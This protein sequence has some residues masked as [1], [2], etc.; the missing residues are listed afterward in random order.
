MNPYV[1][2]VK[3][4]ADYQLELTFENGKIR[5]FDLKPYLNRG[6]FARLA[7]IGKFKSAHVAAD[8]VE[9]QGEI[10]LSYDTLY[11]ESQPIEMAGMDGR[12]SQSKR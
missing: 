8:S 4:L 3:P 10:D 11:S 1:K 12:R 2:E 7:D 5:V 9:W 6:V